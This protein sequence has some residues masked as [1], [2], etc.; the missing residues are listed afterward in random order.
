MLKFAETFCNVVVVVEP[1]H[2]PQHFLGRLRLVDVDHVAG[3]ARDFAR[4]GVMPGV[5]QRLRHGM[6]RGRIAGD[7][8][9]AVVGPL[10]VLCPGLEGPVHQL[11]F[12]DG[13]GGHEK[14]ALLLEHPGDASRCCLVCRRKARIS[15][16]FHR[17]CGCDC[18]S[19]LAEDGDAA[20]A[21]A[22][23]DDLF[24]VAASSSPVPRLIARWMFSLGML[25]ALASSMA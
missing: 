5:G 18:R 16:G 23:V 2:Q 17:R 3:D 21:V 4:L 13:G 14:Q 10:H 11:V 6:E 24:E 15:F 19:A 8:E 1:V 22:L 7:L 12:L 20:G 25:T 9:L